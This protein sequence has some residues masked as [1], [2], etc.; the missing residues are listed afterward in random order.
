MLLFLLPLLSHTHMKGRLGPP[1]S[2]DP[3]IQASTCMTNSLSHQMVKTVIKPKMLHHQMAL[4]CSYNSDAA[5]ALVCVLQATVLLPK[6]MLELR[7][8]IKGNI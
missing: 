8:T 3:E 7:P 1:K 5:G 6:I 2:P 4:H